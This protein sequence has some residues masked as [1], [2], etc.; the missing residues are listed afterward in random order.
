MTDS[1]SSKQ[2]D[3]EKAA[4]AARKA[5][6]EA[7][8]QRQVRDL[9]ARRTQQLADARQATNRIQR[10]LKAMRKDAHRCEEIS[11]HLDGFYLE[12]NKLA[13]KALMEATPLVVEQVNDIIRDAKEI[14]KGDVYLDRTKEFVPAGDNPP[15]SDVLVTASAVRQSLGRYTK[16]TKDQSAKLSESLSRARTLVVAL[17]YYLN[18]NGSEPL[19]KAEV[20]TILDGKAASFCFSQDDAFD[21][22]FDLERLDRQTLEGYLSMEEQE[23]EAESQENEDPQER[24]DQAQD[25]EA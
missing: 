10:E 8:L 23:S 17:E 21:Y 11:N 4:R 1:G 9:R 22:H 25:E 5:E 2:A 7:E 14:I 6:Q 18:E 3:A 13:K 15:Y 20:E 24:A 16:H 12:I 19:L